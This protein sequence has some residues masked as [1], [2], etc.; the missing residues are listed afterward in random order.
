M[1]RYTK[2]LCAVTLTVLAGLALC[3]TALAH[4]G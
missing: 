4:A 2:N 1:G 3:S